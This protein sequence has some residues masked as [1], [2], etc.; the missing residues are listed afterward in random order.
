MAGVERITWQPA[1]A[2]QSHLEVLEKENVILADYKK[3]FHNL[4]NLF[5]QKFE[6][7]FEK[8]SNILLHGDCHKG[9]FI[10]RPGEGVY[11]VDFDD[12]IN[13][14]KNVSTHLCQF[15]EIDFDGNMLKATVN[16]INVK[17]N[18][19]ENRKNKQ[20]GIFYKTRHKELDTKDVP[21]IYYTIW[22]AFNSMKYDGII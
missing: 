7:M 4:S 13:N 15:L 9:N 11:L 12:I 8:E 2:T 17:G 21:D 5:M 22:D 6:P 1:I 14:T 3:P 20:E 18:S 10:Y 16:G 19:S